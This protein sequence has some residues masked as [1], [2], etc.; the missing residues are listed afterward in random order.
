M[1]HSI[2]R[3]SNADAVLEQ[4]DGS[5]I[6]VK[7]LEETE[8]FSDFLLYVQN[9]ERSGTNGHIKYAQTQNDN[10]RNEYETLF[11]DVPKDI[12]FARIALQQAPDAI[13]FW[14]GNSQSVTSLHKDNYENIYAQIRGQKHFVL[15]PPL[16]APCVNEQSLVGTTYVRAQQAAVG[17]SDELVAVVDEPVATVPVA[18]WDPDDAESRTTSFSRLAQ[19]MRVTLDEGDLLYLPAM[20][21]HKVSQS[22]GDEGFCCAV[23]YWYVCWKY[24]PVSAAIDNNTGTTWISAARSGPRTTLSDRLHDK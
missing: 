24:S 14:L 22:C 6:F 12:P 21:Y 2:N 15:L 13:N 8:T 1:R 20:W 9:Q 16:A 23:N 11:A 5:T 17:V 7:P 18:T 4:E 3:E 19:P 10:L